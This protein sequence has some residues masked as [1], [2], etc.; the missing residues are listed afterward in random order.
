MKKLISR[1]LLLSIL[2]MIGAPS[3]MALTTDTAGEKTL[4]IDLGEHAEIVNGQYQNSVLKLS[5]GGKVVYN[6][7][8]PFN[9][10]GIEMKYTS[11]ESGTNLTVMMNEKSYTKALT[12]SSVTLSLN[13]Y[14]HKG[15]YQMILKVDKEI[16]IYSILIRRPQML[17]TLLS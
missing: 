8:I 7:Y 17:G 12:G 4:D 16:D 11:K 10:S 2:F 14:L 9:A 13:P 6:M 1:I 5:A 15:Q 3:A